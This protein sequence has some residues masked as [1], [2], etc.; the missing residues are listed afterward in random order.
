MKVWRCASGFDGQRL[1]W[2][3]GAAKCATGRSVVPAEQLHGREQGEADEGDECAFRDAESQKRPG[4][5]GAV[6]SP[7]EK[8]AEDLSQR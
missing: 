7:A 6:C 5:G 3:S 8:K 2:F 1:A 4:Y